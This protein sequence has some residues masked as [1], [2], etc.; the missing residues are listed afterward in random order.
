MFIAVAVVVGIKLSK[1]V[2]NIKVKLIF[3]NAICS[4]M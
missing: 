2:E 1:Y 3:K 4:T